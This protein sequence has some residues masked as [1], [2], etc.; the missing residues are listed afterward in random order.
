MPI[1]FQEFVER[2]PI[3]VVCSFRRTAE[4]SY[5]YNA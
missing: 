5:S 4:I 3:A 2:I 1:G